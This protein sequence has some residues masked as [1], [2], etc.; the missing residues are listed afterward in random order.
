MAPYGDREPPK[1]SEM[2]KPANAL[3]G[4][5]SVFEMLKPVHRFFQWKS[6]LGTDD[7]IDGLLS[8]QGVLA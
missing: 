3:L 2:I 4:I 5:L 7:N 6:A 1:I 8:C